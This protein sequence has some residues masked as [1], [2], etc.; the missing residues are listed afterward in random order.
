M[1]FLSAKEGF[2]LHYQ[3]KLRLSGIR[4]GME[5]LALKNKF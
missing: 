1:Q 4:P 2:R 5:T 3:S